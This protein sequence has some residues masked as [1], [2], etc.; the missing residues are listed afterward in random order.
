MGGAYTIKI[1]EFDNPKF[2]FKNY[3][4][5]FWFTII[6]GFTVGYGD[7]V[8]YSLFGRVFIFVLAILGIIVAN[9]ATANLQ[10]HLQFS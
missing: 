6:T 8:P 4:K 9:L 2:E 1:L 3:F 10:Y 5:S 7:M